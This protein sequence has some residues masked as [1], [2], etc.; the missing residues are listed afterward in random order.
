MSG[1]FR[2]S[3]GRNSLYPSGTPPRS[4]IIDNL[5]AWA[6]RLP[7]W[8]LIILA[9]LVI[10]WY[11]MFSSEIYRRALRFVSQD[12]QISTNRI[13][14]VLYEVRQP[15]GSTAE[16]SGTLTGEDA[17]TVTVITTDEV[18]VIIP[19]T[20]LAS[21]GCTDD[22][23]GSK[24]AI[25][26]T[27]TVVRKTAS[28]K[29]IF[30]SLGAYTIRTLYGSEDILKIGTASV[31]KSPQDC[32]A[33]PNGN[34]DIQ[35][36]LKPDRKENTISGG[37]LASDTDTVTIQTIPPE[38][39]TLNKSSIIATKNYV[40]A[41][42]ALNNLAACNEGPYLTLWVTLASFTLA[43][44]LGLALG[45][46]RVSSNIVLYNVSTVYVEVIRGIPLLV[47][48]LFVGFAIE[49]WFHTNF[50][51]IAPTAS[52]VV[53]VLTVV[54]ALYYLITRWSR[55]IT[56]PAELMQPLIFTI[57]FGLLALLFVA[58]LNERSTTNDLAQRAIQAAI[59]GLGV[60]YG[61]F[62]AELF[63]AGI[64]SIGKGQTEAARSLGMTYVQAMRFVILPQA[65]RVILPPLGNDFIAMLK[66]TS[67]IT[68]LAVPELTQRARLFASS[69]YRPFETYVTIAVL[70]LCMTLFLSFM[71]RVVERRMN[72]AR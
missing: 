50:A 44:I 24:C 37:L 28:G 57:V 25:N 8:A 61:A 39:V 32:S 2:E 27:V 5:I 18:R 67:L 63:R 40:P 21:L 35:L 56:D 26:T 1:N 62:L 38:T 51:G 66:D 59:V 3:R 7:W 46:M 9:G 48:L 52:L 12:P 10:A 11:S 34:C 20:D 15:N 14:N 70:Y 60:G 41:Q 72:L 22:P 16:V 65:F 4:S 53:L 58:I 19:R 43:I 71:V 69:T 47:I 55:R 29:L 17:N 64:Q 23:S 31:V 33:D 49:P 45:L 68:I 6:A 42:C 13:A 54:I 30:E 36:T